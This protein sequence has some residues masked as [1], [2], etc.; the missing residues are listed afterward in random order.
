MSPAEVARS[1][2]ALTRLM[3]IAVALVAPPLSVTS[4]KTRAE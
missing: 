2:V 4:K 3:Y 1:S